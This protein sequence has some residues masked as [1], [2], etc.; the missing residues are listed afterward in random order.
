MRLNETEFFD[1]VP[2]EA[3][4]FRV[5]GYQ[6][7]FKWLDDRVDRALTQSDITHYRRM[8]AAMRETVALLPAVDAAFHALLEAFPA[9]S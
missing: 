7:A 4:E 6:P 8:I 1:N 3:W 9:S 2:P 5:G